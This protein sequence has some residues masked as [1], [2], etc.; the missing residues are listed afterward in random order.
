[1]P[2]SSGIF[3]RGA[4]KLLIGEFRNF[5]YKIMFNPFNFFIE[6]PRVDSSVGIE[7]GDVL[8]GRGS[9]PRR[10]QIFF[11]TP[12]RRDRLWGSPNLLSNG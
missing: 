10:G 3:S 2:S 1:M 8:D 6:L 4:T 7:V 12:Q 5:A 9:I 11:S